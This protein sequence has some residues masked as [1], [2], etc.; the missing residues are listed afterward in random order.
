MIYHF[1]LT[2]YGPDF[3]DRQVMRDQ[4]SVRA[5]TEHEARRKLVILCHDNGSFVRGIISMGE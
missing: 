4:V 3:G 2:T 5:A 1:L